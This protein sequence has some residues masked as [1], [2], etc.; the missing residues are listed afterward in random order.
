MKNKPLFSILLVLISAVNSCAFFQGSAG[1]VGV[2][3]FYQNIHDGITNSGSTAS[4]PKR[5]FTADNLMIS[6][7][8][9][10][11][12]YIIVSNKCVIDESA[13]LIHEI[14]SASSTNVFRYSLDTYLTIYRS[15]D[16]LSNGDIYTR[17]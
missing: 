9:T 8:N 15:A 3:N 11:Y 1:L 7:Y 5:E 13:K 4:V 16:N 2:W 14:V 6:T 17:Q 10:G 12:Y